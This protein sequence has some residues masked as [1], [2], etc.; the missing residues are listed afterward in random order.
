MIII[1]L[2]ITLP[3]EEVQRLEQWFRQNVDPQAVLDIRCDQKIIG[4]CQIIWRGFEGDFSLRKKLRPSFATP[5]RQGFEG[6]VATEGKE[7]D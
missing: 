3:K 6:Q 5:L 1:T 7:N 2:A 4:G